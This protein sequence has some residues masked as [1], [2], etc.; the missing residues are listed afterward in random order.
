MNTKYIDKIKEN[1]NEWFWEDDKKYL[2][3]S[4]DLDGYLSASL[5]LQHRPSW[6]IGGFI[7]DRKSV[8]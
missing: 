6:E 5:L 3:V 2:I 4:D 8:V 1:G 7:S